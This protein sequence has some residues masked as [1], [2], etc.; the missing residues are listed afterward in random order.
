MRKTFGKA[1][2]IA[3]NQDMAAPIVWK[4]FYAQQSQTATISIFGLGYYEL[5]LNGERVGEDFFK[6]ALSDYCK[7]DLSQFQYPSFDETS[8]RVYYNTY[9]VRVQEGENTIAVLLGDGFFRQTQ[10][11]DE[12]NTSFAD[13]LM[14]SFSIVLKDSLVYTDGTE[15]CTESFIVENNIF[16]GETHDYCLWDKESLAKNIS[17]A[18]H[19]VTVVEPNAILTKQ[20]CPN[21]RIEKILIPKLISKNGDRKIYDVGENITGFVR[22]CPLSDKV[23][24]RHAESLIDGVLNY[25]STGGVGQIQKMEYNNA[26]NR[27]VHPWFHWSGFR[28]FEIEGEVAEKIEVCVIH[29]FISKTAKFESGNQVLNWLFEAYIRTQKGNL[30]GGITMDCPHRERLGYTGDGQ[31]VAE[32]AMLLL[33][34]KDVFA[35]WIQDIAD[36]QDRKTGHIQHTAPFMGGGGGPGGW[37]SAIV[38]VPYAYYKVYGDKGILKKYFKNMNRFL[39]CMHEFC[40]KGLVVRERKGGWC[41]GDWCTPSRVQIPEPLVNTFYFIRSMNIV[42][43]IAD[44]LNEKVDYDNW[45]QESKEAIVRTYY[46]VRTGDFCEDIQGAN[47]YGL[48]LDLG[49]ARTKQNT[50]NK[51]RKTQSFDTGI[52]GTELL[53][54]YLVQEGEIQLLLNLLTG[55]NFPSFGYMKKNGATTLWEGWRNEGSLNHPMMGGCIKQIIYGIL[56]IHGDAGFSNLTIKPPYLTGLGYISAELYLGNKKVELQ[57]EYKNGNVYADVRVDGMRF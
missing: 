42:R 39:W 15:V 25:D 54:E 57:Y 21:E 33:D 30:H 38:L 24:V 18:T 46:D 29:T 10:R 35:K 49:D 31:L 36:C 41:L 27:I 17:R 40:D 56:G 5:F 3:C 12:G 7:R 47:I 8:H 44:I 34:C 16:N 53:S 13:R 14:L 11:L 2:W 22:L 4:T 55:E 43:E 52:F 20:K 45:I 48:L 26:K 19:P 1:K 28:Y 50:L 51:Y 37:G 9:K 6:P 23:I 32:S